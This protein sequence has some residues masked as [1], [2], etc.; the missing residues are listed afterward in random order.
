MLAFTSAQAFRAVQSEHRAPAILQASARWV[1]P[2]L[3]ALQPSPR[4]LTALTL[5]AG[6]QLLHLKV[7]GQLWK[8]NQTAV[9][10]SAALLQCHCERPR[11]SNAGSNAGQRS[12]LG[13][14][15][16]FSLLNH[17]QCFKAGQR[18]EQWTENRP[19]CK[20]PPEVFLHLLPAE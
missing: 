10:R 11:S 19:K 20:V 3:G 7:V 15:C 6:L 4:V 12:V 13:L 16:S 17:F 9:R 1:P 8:R 18:A 5:L 2:P 14:L